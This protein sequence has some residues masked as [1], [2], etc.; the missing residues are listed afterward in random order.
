MSDNRQLGL[1]TGF[2]ELLQIVT[3]RNYS[4]IANSYTLQFTTARTKFSQSSVSS[5]RCRLVTASNTV[6]SS[7]SRLHSYC[8]AT[9]SQTNFQAGGHLT[10]NSY[11][12]DWH[13]AVS[14]LYSL[15]TMSLTNQLTLFHC[16]ALTQL[17]CV[18]GG[19]SGPHR[20]HRSQQF[21]CCVT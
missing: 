5:T 20:K 6:V 15:S 11:S 10:P 19:S 12:S 3:R 17:N 9:V 1:V 7:A 8:P 16:T 4:A 18:G 13:A 21:C 2:I 14:K